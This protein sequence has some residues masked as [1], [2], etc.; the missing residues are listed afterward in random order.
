MFAPPIFI[1]GYH[2]IKRATVAVFLSLF[3]QLSHAQILD[4]NFLLSSPNRL[5]LSATHTYFDRNLD[6]VDYLDSLPGGSRP[7]RF[8]RTGLMIGYKIGGWRPFLVYQDVSGSVVR[9]SQPEKVRSDAA[10]TAAGLSYLLG[11]SS[12]G[13]NLEVKLSDHRQDE[14]TIDCYERS[15]VVLGG[16]CAEADFQ[17]IDGDVLLNTGDRVALPVLTSSAK[18]ISAE[19]SIDWWNRLSSSPLLIGHSVSL[20]ASEVQHQNHSPLYDLQSTF[21]LNA[22]FNNQTLGQI[23]ENL[24]DDLPQQSPWREA[25]IRYDLSVSVFNGNWVF[26]SSIG[27]LYTKRFDFTDAL[28][29]QQYSTNYIASGEIWYQFKNGAI[30]LKGEAFSNYLLGTDPLAYTNKS[31][32]FF[33]HPYGQVSLGFIVTML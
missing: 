9:S 4:T 33:D 16:A 12:E 22:E 27:A 13:A 20:F 7:E 11:D 5:S 25:T 6:I 10:Y 3:C 14:V 31:S 23:I 32:R 28:N 19:L 18:A 15:G 8:S 1:G 17:L 2:F 21:L 26:G 30:F 24:K 29:R